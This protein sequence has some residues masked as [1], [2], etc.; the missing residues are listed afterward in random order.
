MKLRE[1]LG[2][3]AC[4][5][6]GIAC[7]QSGESE[8]G[9]TIA[10]LCSSNDDCSAAESCD[11]RMGAGVC[12]PR[13]SD[14]HPAAGGGGRADASTG[15]CTSAADCAF[16]Y[17]CEYEHGAGYC[18]AH[19]GDDD[20]DLYDAD[21]GCEHG[22]DCRHHD[23]TP[24]YDA[25]VPST[26]KTCSK[27]DDC[28]YYERCSYAGSNSGHGKSGEGSS[29]RGHGGDDSYGQPSTGVCQSDDESG[30]R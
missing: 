13:D 20:D 22:D 9:G 6:F 27:D 14:E 12:R 17:E 8:A 21:A 10:K 24:A 18:K 26:H 7:T 28:G 16:G 19:G 23:G 15:A 3:F 30:R 29:G 4:F 2:F 25:G 1:L 5:A 11:L